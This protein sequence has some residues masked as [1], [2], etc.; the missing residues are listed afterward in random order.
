MLSQGAT[1][2]WER[3][4]GYYSQ[5]HSCFTSPGGWFY[6]G[7]TGIRTDTKAPGF[8]KIMIKPAIVGK[9][10]WVQTYYDSPYGRIISNWRRDTNR[11]TMEVTIPTNATATVFVVSND[12]TAVIESGRPA[13]SAEAVTFLSRQDNIAVRE[14]GSVT[15]RFQSILS[16]PVK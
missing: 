13:N 4:N 3:W 2:Y 8:K 10:A 5:I 12:A 15:Y 6:Q 7:L 9:L 16:E 1:T 14:L 11:L